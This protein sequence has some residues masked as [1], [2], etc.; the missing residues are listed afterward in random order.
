MLRAFE[1]LRINHWRLLVEG[2]LL[3]VLPL[4]QF[5]WTLHAKNGDQFVL[6][7]KGGGSAVGIWRGRD[8]S[9]P[10]PLISTILTADK[11]T[12]R[13]EARYQRAQGIFEGVEVPPW[14]ATASDRPTPAQLR[15]LNAWHEVGLRRLKG[16]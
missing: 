8:E 12:G 9:A 11:Y 2:E 3:P 16:Y 14:P 5:A 15:A 7:L 1:R 6:P 13:Q 10:R 4:L